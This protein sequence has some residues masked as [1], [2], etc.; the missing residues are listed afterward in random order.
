MS[1]RLWQIRKWRVQRGRAPLKLKK[2]LLA[3]LASENPERWK[4]WPLGTVFPT[5]EKKKERNMRKTFG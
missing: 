3:E 1:S 4:H 5:V 2:N